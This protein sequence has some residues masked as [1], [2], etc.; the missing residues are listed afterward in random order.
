MTKKNNIL[1][2]ILILCLQT[3]VSGHLSNAHKKEKHKPKIFQVRESNNRIYLQNDENN[4]NPDV[5][6]RFLVN[7]ADLEYR[8]NKPHALKT[9]E[10]KKILIK[11][12]IPHGL[13]TPSLEY[14]HLHDTLYRPLVKYHKTVK[15]DKNYQNDNFFDYGNDDEEILFVGKNLG[16]KINKHGST[17]KNNNDFNRLLLQPFKYEP[18]KNL[19]NGQQNEIYRYENDDNRYGNGIVTEADD[20]N[21]KNKNKPNRNLKKKYRHNAYYDRKDKELAIQILKEIQKLERTV[22]SKKLK[23]KI[24]ADVTDLLDQLTQ[25]RSSLYAK[26]GENNDPLQRYNDILIKKNKKET[27]KYFMHAPFY[28]DIPLTNFWTVS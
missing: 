27:A 13:E 15:K 21:Y 4:Y 25:L 8:V 19:L 5:L 6:K 1:K 9:R 14:D 24:H 10:L 26:S 23:R 28:H 20:Y 16:S 7:N 11:R 22:K 3:L 18:S 17:L 2:Y 12:K